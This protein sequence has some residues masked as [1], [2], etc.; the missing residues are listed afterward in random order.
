MESPS[1]TRRTTEDVAAGARPP[2]LNRPYAFAMASVSALFLA[3]VG[4]LGQLA[5]RE[6]SVLPA[7]FPRYLASTVVV[8]IVLRGDALQTLKAIGRLDW[9]RL[10]SVLISQFC[11]FYYLAHGSLLIGM[12]LYNTGPLFSPILARLLLG[13]TFGIRTVVSLLLGF[14]GVA[15]VLNPFGETLDSI[16]LVALASG[17]FNACS[18]LAFHQM[19]H[20][21]ESP[22]RSLFPF[23]VLLT[24]S[25][26]VQLPFV[27][28][29]TITALE[30]LRRWQTLAVV[31]GLGNFGVLINTQNP[32]PI[33]TCETPQTW[34][35]SFTFRS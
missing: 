26:V 35:H 14:A 27:W 34:G 22:L 20:L 2:T 1:D 19:S 5:T 32:S 11:L 16:V 25:S 33:I 30:Q 10:A 7:L 18:Q 4:L 6:L 31:I 21:E 12:L 8:L 15:L 24:L 3:L 17:F 9:L 28:E 13:I 29:Q 23:Y